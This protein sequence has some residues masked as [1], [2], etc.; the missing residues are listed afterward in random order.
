MPDVVQTVDV[1]DLDELV[2]VTEVA[3]GSGDFAVVAVVAPFRTDCAGLREARAHPVGRRVNVWVG[4][5]GHLEFHGAGH[6]SSAPVALSEA[7]RRVGQYVAWAGSTCGKN[8]C[9]M[10]GAPLVVGRRSL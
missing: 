9:L 4:A 6:V 10:D 7:L 2:F 8:V 1:E 3:V 5:F